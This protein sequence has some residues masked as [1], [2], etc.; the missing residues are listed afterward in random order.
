MDALLT[1]RTVPLFNGLPEEQLEAIAE[2]ASFKR[3]KSG[4]HVALESDHVRAFFLVISGRVKIYKSSAEGK[5]QTMYIFGSGEPFCLR[6]AFADEPFPANAQAL[7]DSLVLAVPSAQ[8]EK[9]ARTQPTLMFNMVTVLSRR[10]KESMQLVESLALKEIP[11]RLAAFILH[12]LDLSGR[13]EAKDLTLDITQRELAKIL[14]AT[15]ETLSRVLK[16]LAE[17]EIISIKGRTI[18]IHDRQAL[19]ELA[20]WF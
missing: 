9:L 15:P 2:T 12:T 19:E 6:T 1:L 5:E 10:L 20:D 4:E 18:L 17:D 8:M 11:E 7:E 16:R 13:G 3:Y 14:G